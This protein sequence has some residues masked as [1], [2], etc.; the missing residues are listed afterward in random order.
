L[1]LGAQDA[2]AVEGVCVDGEG[3]IRPEAVGQTAERL[4]QMAG[5]AVPLGT[6]LLT[7]T[8]ASVGRAEVFSGEIL[9]S[10]LAWHEVGSADEGIEFCG[11]LLRRGGLGHSAVVWS[12][13]EAVV[14]AFSRLPAGRINV[15]MPGTWGTAGLVSPIEPS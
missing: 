13:D 7:V 11:R 6:T 14:L 10:T 15:N 3:H 5:I 12:E 4:G 8:I 9:T 2:R 1:F